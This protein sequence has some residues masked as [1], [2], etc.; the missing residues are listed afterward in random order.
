MIPKHPPLPIATPLAHRDTLPAGLPAYWYDMGIDE[1]AVY[2]AQNGESIPAAAF[3][4]AG[5]EAG[6]RRMDDARIARGA[7]PAHEAAVSRQLGSVETQGG[8]VAGYTESI[9]DF[10]RGWPPEARRAGQEV[11]AEL[12][13]D[14]VNARMLYDILGRDRM[15]GRVMPAKFQWLHQNVLHASEAWS[16]DVR[17]LASVQLMHESAARGAKVLLR[18][19]LQVGHDLPAVDDSSI[20]QFWMTKIAGTPHIATGIAYYLGY[21]AKSRPVL[22]ETM[23]KLWGADYKESQALFN[24]ALH[25]NTFALDDQERAHIHE[26]IRLP[27]FRFIGQGNFVKARNALQH[28]AADRPKLFS[29]SARRFLLQQTARS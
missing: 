21:Q 18:C 16:P 1:Q 29:L 11:M 28:A 13:P 10:P 24:H 22:E 27:V 20:E 4:A 26:A 6:S 3:A 2:L 8:Y 12:R 9:S 5:L 17:A 14:L 25:L 23:Q 15:T 19:L 7:L